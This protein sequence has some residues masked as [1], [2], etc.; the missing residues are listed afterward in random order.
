MQSTAHDTGH[1]TTPRTRQVEHCTDCT[2]AVLLG[3]GQ[4]HFCQC[5]LFC[6]TFSA[7]NGVLIERGP[8]LVPIKTMPNSALGHSEL[9]LHFHS[10][11]II[12]VLVRESY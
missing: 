4:Q 2:R 10:L 6:F 9:Y 11:G 5:R 12:L 3:S 7:A 1:S 8:G